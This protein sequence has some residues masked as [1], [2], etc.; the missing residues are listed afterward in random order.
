MANQR[1]LSHFSTFLAG[2]ASLIGVP[3]SRITTELA[4]TAGTFFGTAMTD[5][6]NRSP[7]L[8]VSPY[9]EARFLGN[10]LTYGNNLAK[11]SAW[12]ATAVTATGNSIAN[13]ADGFVTAS[14]L[15]ETA[16]NSTHKVVQ[17]VTD[18]FPSTG[19]TVSFYARPNGRSYQYLSVFDGVTTYTAF[20]NTTTGTVGTTANFATVTIG[21]QPNGFWL[22]QATFTANAAATS[23]GTAT[24]QLSSDGTTLSYAGDTAKGAYFW[25]ALVQQTTLVPVQDSIIAW[26]QTGENAIDAVIDVY[27]QN[28]FST[29]Y[30]RSAGYNVTQAGVQVINSTPYNY[31]WYNQGVA[32]SSVYGA[33]PANPVFLYY[34]KTMP[35]WTGDEF[36]S[37]ATYAVD[38]QVYFVNSLG[39][40][41]FWKCTVATTAGQDPDDTPAS[42][43]LVP[44]YQTFLQ[45]CI[46]HAYADWLTADGQGDKALSAYGIAEGKLMDESDKVERIMGQVMPMKV[47]THLTSRAAY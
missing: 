1:Q 37:T 9:G 3:A 4:A 5:M 38:Q 32:Q 20:F 2:W 27:L 34:R 12:T 30:P 36:D 43:E 26:N 46:Y 33:S 13:P 8:E 45:F 17:N 42:W 28:P 25:G 41:D 40:G 29:N 39:Q 15:M 11:T 47:S 14:K 31:T 10:R 22:C 18:F 35:S 19:Y 44:V 21:Q 6:W 7:W 23:A 16:A 24:L